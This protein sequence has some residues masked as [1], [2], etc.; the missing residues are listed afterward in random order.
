[1]TTERYRIADDAHVY[2][3]TDSVV[4][5]LPIVISEAAC[6]IVTDSLDFCHQKKNLRTNAFVIMPTHMLA[7][8]LTA[9]AISAVVCATVCA[10]LASSS[11]SSCPMRTV[12]LRL[13]KLA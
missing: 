12:V 1:M 5:W 13:G 11:A 6:K 10:A 8:A 4:E 3:V 7:K 2:F 9:V